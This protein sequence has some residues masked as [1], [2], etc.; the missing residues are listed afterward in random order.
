MF[1]I[2]YRVVCSEEESVIVVANSNVKHSHA[3]GEY[4]VRV[5]QCQEATTA[6]Q[7]INELVSSLRHATMVDLEKA[8][9]LLSDI[10]YKRAKHVISEN[11]RTL[12]A[13]D[14][15]E[16][17]DMVNF[18]KL[19]NGSHESMKN[20]YEVGIFYNVDNIDTRT[21]LH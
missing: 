17:G 7:T 11:E 16:S 5:K 10:I 9:H 13:K 21:Y 2:I 1:L 6:L 14:C 8:K 19:M 15:F 3:N 18:G 20:D 4:P 12:A